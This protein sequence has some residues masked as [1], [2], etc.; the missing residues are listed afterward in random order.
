[1]RP[2]KGAGRV[3]HR[4]WHTGFLR[5]STSVGLRRTVS[6]Q[7]ESG[8]MGAD[9]CQYVLL[10]VTT[11][12]HLFTVSETRDESANSTSISSIAVDPGTH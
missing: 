3:A 5:C 9:D 4:T 6:E 2:T 1:M 12:P 7:V 8:A 10:S 11:E